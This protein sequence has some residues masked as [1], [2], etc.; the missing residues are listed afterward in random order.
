[1]KAWEDF[2][3]AQEREIGDAAV[4]HWLRSLKV[5]HFDAANLYLEA[6][7]AL[8]A[9]WF[10]E[11][12]RYKVRTALK[13]NNQRPIKVHLSIAA[14]Q[15]V[16]KKAKKKESPPLFNAPTDTL[17][18]AALLDNF[19]IGKAN[20]LP[21]KLLE[22]VHKK[23]HFNPIFIHGE[24]GV[25]KTHLLMALTHMLLEKGVV[26]L[27]V[28]TETFTDHFVKAMRTG[29][30]Q[31]FR[32][33]YRRADVLLV[34]DVQLLSRRA[35]TQEEFFH[36][37]NH[38]HTTG[39]QI[40]L[41]A[42]FLPRYFSEVEA[43]LVSRFEWGISLH[44]EKLSESESKKL[45]KKRCD[46]LDFPLDEEAISFL[47][48]SFPSSNKALCQALDALV[49]RT[50]LNKG[51]KDKALLLADLIAKERGAALTPD[52]II[53]AVAGYFD[54]GS[55]ELLGKAQTQECALPR[56]I[57]MH[58]CRSELKLPY[59]QIG[60]VFSRDHSTVMTSVR[61][62]AD[63]CESSDKQ[64]SQ[65]IAEIRRQLHT[66]PVIPSR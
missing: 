55:E 20:E 35:A 41:A 47:V 36:T 63:K 10:E 56:Q 8:Q 65:A 18:P 45:V 37:F 6:K 57:A 19:V 40:I 32:K 12:M 28:R 1:M 4:S 2:L 59:M 51:E 66:K 38:L 13:N 60:K 62:I 58:L 22:E 46:L 30:M 26:A 39:R 29:S 54:V 53:A 15:V 16:E 34:D 21:L 42:P 31:E 44:L 52:K 17:D 3:Q 49:L 64:I 25:G 11:Q 48:K 9:N 43:R 61:R 14:M 24:E 33:I 50:H 5:V 27:F 7:D 23:A